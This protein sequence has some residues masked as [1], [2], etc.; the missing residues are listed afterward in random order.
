MATTERH[1]LSSKSGA[2]IIVDTLA[3]YLY[4]AVDMRA[5]ALITAMEQRLCHDEQVRE[6]LEE[7]LKSLSSGY[8]KYLDVL[9]QLKAHD[10]SIE[11]LKAIVGIGA[12][13]APAIQYMGPETP[14][15]A[16]EEAANK[17]LRRNLE[18]W[19]AVE[20]YLRFVPEAKVREILDFMELIKIRTSRQAVEAAITAHPKVFRVLKRKQEKF[21]SLK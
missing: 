18:L 20:Q 1:G 4:D 9:G 2:N 12:A 6:K 7:E 21:V 10:R 8:H 3:R 17:K 14:E 5:T 13:P 16:D 11:R 19:E 15:D